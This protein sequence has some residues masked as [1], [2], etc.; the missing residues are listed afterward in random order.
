MI[1]SSRIKFTI[2]LL[3]LIKLF[4][5]IYY[6]INVT[7]LYKKHVAILGEK[8]LAFLIEKFQDRFTWR[9]PSYILVEVA[10]IRRC[11]YIAILKIAIIA[12]TFRNKLRA[13]Q[14]LK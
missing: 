13:E 6:K 2:K 5:I 10:R 9:F 3:N 11:M 4:Y 8:N 1:L 7:V 14:N 12:R